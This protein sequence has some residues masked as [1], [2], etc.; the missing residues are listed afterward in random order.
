MPNE[1]PDPA[2]YHRLLRVIFSDLLALLPQLFRHGNHLHVKVRIIHPSLVELPP[3]LLQLL[4][5]RP[6][7]DLPED[8]SGSASSQCQARPF[9]D[10]L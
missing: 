6:F 4:P 1:L 3:C 7:G 9:R 10:V 8:V 5:I 2:K